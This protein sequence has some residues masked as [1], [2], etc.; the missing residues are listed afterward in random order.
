MIYSTVPFSSFLEIEFK[1]KQNKQTNK[2][3]WS[4]Y[5]ACS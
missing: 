4:D 3:I 5:K 2:S 1:K